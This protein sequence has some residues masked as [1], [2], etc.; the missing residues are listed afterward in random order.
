MHRINKKVHIDKDELVHIKAIEGDLKTRFIAFQFIS[1]NKPIDLTG[2]NVRV[3]GNTSEFYN[4]EIFNDLVIEDEK[5]GIA[6]LELTSKFLI[7][8][9]TKYQLHIFKGEGHL[10]SNIFELE[11]GESLLNQ[12]AYESSNEF[13]AFE[14]ALGKI[15]GYDTRL[16]TAENTIKSANEEIGITK[17]AVVETNKKVTK[18]TNDIAD[19]NTS[20]A[21]LLALFTNNK[22]FTKDNMTMTQTGVDT[23]T[24]IEIPFANQTL[25]IEFGV[26]SAASGGG[27]KMSYIQNIIW[28]MGCL[29]ATNPFTFAYYLDGTNTLR[30]KHGYTGNLMVNWIAFGIK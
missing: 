10:S 11:V 22:F 24:Y 20:F 12:D 21:P 18:N 1:N 17:N 3:S 27:V 26:Y 8:G 7:K 13:K 25:Q 29:R 5:K 6:V 14:N 15:D 16:R 28:G 23:K 19:I 30:F 4:N 2:C 9:I